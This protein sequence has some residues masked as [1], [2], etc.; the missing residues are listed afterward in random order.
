[1][2]GLDSGQTAIEIALPGCIFLLPQSKAVT[3]LMLRAPKELD[4]LG[5][6]V[7]QLKSAVNQRRKRQLKHRHPKVFNDKT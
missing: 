3:N 5:L 4:K 1:L 6:N 2:L 7:E